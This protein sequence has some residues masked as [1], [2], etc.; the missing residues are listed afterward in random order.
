[1]EHPLSQ[2][3]EKFNLSF[4]SLGQQKKGFR[5]HRLTHQHRWGQ[6]LHLTHSPCVIIIGLIKE[7]H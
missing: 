7:G 4:R 5:Q 6:A 2:Q 3:Q 1:M